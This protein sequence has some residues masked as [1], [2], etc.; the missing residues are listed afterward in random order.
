MS[1]HNHTDELTRTSK[2]GCTAN[3]MGDMNKTGKSRSTSR[4]RSD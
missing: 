4:G 3:R 2:Y 1:D